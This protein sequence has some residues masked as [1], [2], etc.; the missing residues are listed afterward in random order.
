MSLHQQAFEG[1]G[2]VPYRHPLQQPLLPYEKRLIQA[3]GCTEE[4]YRQFAQEV[5]RRVTERPEEYAHIPDVQNVDL[6][7]SFLISLA[8]SA[9]FTAASVLLA[10]KPPDFNNRRVRQKKLGGVQGRDIYTPT[11]GFES[12]QDLAEY[13]Q[14]VPIAFT[15]KETLPNG[16]TS[17]GLLVSPQLVW[18]RMKSRYSFQIAEM[19]M[20]VGQGPID[21]PDL[22]G[23]FL[24]N[25]ALDAL[26]DDYFDF[27]YTSGEAAKS[28]LKGFH[29]RYGDF[30]G[31]DLADDQEAFTAPANAAQETTA[32]CGAFTPSSQTRF[33]VYS[34]IP[35]GTPYRPDWRII[36][37]P[38]KHLNATAERQ[39]KN[40]Q[41]KYVDQF[42][43]D[44]HPK[45]GNAV[46]DDKQKDKRGSEDAGMPGTGTNYARRV[47]IVKHIRAT[48]NFETTANYNV[49]KTSEHG[50]ES[51]EDVKKEVK[52]T[53][54]FNKFLQKNNLSNILIISDEDSLK[55]IN[56]S[57]RNIKDLKLIKHEG[58]NIYDL[59]KYK[60]VILTSTSVKKI[61]ERILNE[62]N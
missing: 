52:K 47:G 34:G 33:G 36:S 43:M 55:N 51:W 16:S 27:F 19:V 42:L 48:D 21:R 45:G 46:Q 10:P 41:K 11:V 14:I 39:K 57:A 49:R 15:R 13:G 24:G 4:E 23:I 35:N 3:L 44:V 31:V 5:E 38:Q 54:D 1:G 40:E 8:V 59:F 12:T 28:R 29:H 61:Q 20:I 32:F 50:H 26:Y 58:A 17:G 62:K 60:N 30:I 2:M 56:K 53:K 18:S 37:I 7:T 22:A 6:G 9:I 25:N